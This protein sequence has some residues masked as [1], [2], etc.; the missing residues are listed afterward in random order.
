MTRPQVVVGAIAVIWRRGRVLVG[1]RAPDVHLGGLLEFP[2]GK[3]EPGETPVACAVREA[4]EE[5]GLDIRVTG[6]RPVLRHAYRDRRVVLYTFDAQVIAGEPGAPFQ[7]IL[8]DDLQDEAFPPAT[9]PLLEALRAGTPATGQG[10]GSTCSC[11]GPGS[12]R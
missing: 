5:T 12:T 1:R 2:G 6:R 7:W 8:P 11:S 3:I 9:A 4:R 10:P